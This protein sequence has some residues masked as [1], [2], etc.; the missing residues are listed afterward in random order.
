MT[1]HHWLAFIQAFFIVIAI[2]MVGVAVH[3]YWL[4]KKDSK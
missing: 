4:W 2:L 1:M 3:E